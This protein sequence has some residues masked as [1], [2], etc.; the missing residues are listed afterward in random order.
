VP[1]EAPPASV[2]AGAEA[3]PALDAEA[4]RRR[5]WPEPGPA[6]FSPADDAQATA[7]AALVRGML[8]GPTDG[9]GALAATAREAGYS[10]E[11]WTIEG[12]RFLAAVELDGRRA[13]GGAVVVRVDAPPGPA[14]ILMAPHGFFDLG[15]ER[16]ALAML[17]EGRD[18]PR[19]LIVNTVHRYLDRDGV[20]RRRADS[21]AD[22]C[23]NPRHLVA[24]ATTAALDALPGAEVV[25]LHGFGDSDED[26]GGPPVAAIVSGGVKEA[27]T[28]RSR[29]VAERLRRELGVEVALFPVDTDRLGA[30]TNVQGR[31]VRARG[32]DGF[33]H[34]EMSA[35]LR[36]RLRDDPAA[37]RALAAALRPTAPRDPSAP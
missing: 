2:G 31:E 17:V 1:G 24:V 34:V 3:Y 16:I 12:Q 4:A 26:A 10:V 7:L 5:L 14:T 28:P 32:R 37:R 19:V 29:E 18:W 25:Q 33:V 20:R 27:P 35:A 21:P 9:P 36:Q 15:T 8:V 6:A 13:G 30:T 11:G 23:H 22:P